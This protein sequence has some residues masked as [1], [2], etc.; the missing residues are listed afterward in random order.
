MVDSA[1]LDVLTEPECLRLLAKVPV[2]RIVYTDQAMPAILPV[3]FV[4][5]GWSVVIRTSAH[6]R[7]AAAGTNSIVAFEV[8]EFSP[9]PVPSG[10]SVV[11]IGPASQ[12][13]DRQ[14]LDTIA[15]LG[16]Q[17]W[18]PGSKEYYLRVRIEVITGRRLTA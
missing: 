12:V 5:D 4:V 3:N 13:T 15:R 6:S 1:G 8:D 11:A 2:G 7:L 9:G 10:W 17:P 18:A 16:L 14:E